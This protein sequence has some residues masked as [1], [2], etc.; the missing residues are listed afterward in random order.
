MPENLNR[1]KEY[2]VV[3]GGQTLPP[4]SGA[5]LGGLAGVK[6]R[7]K[8]EVIDHRIAALIEALKYGD[9]G[10]E[11]IVGAFDDQ[12][13][14]VR[15]AAC[16]AFK[17]PAQLSLLNQ[18]IA[19][20]NKWRA[21][22]AGLK[23]CDVNLSGVKFIG[24]NLRGVNLSEANLS[25]ADFWKTNLSE[26]NLRLAN[27]SGANLTEVDLQGADLLQADL[28]GANLREADLT[29]ANL[30]RANLSG[31]NLQWATMPDGRIHD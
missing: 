23:G 30:S 2:D 28:S 14:R 7:L 5:V 17:K 15:H 18:N 20:W 1:P 8:S 3:L 27:L 16:L 19:V 4:L 13:M 12:A 26:A 11:L 21:H 9:A 6:H 31:A 10:L 24:V 25:G 29:G 22:S